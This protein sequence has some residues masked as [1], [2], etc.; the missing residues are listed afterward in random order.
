MKLPEEEILKRL[1]DIDPPEIN[2]REPKDES[3]SN[4]NQD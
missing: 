3:E 2:L 4:T 1:R